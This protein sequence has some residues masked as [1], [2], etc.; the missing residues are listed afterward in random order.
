M[1]Y[2]AR[3]ADRH[4]QADGSS[5][6]KAMSVL[7]HLL[8]SSTAPMLLLDKWDQNLDEEYN[9]NI[10]AIFEKFANGNQHT[11]FLQLLYQVGE[12]LLLQTST[13]LLPF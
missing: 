2:Q 12:E 9:G 1:G 13:F 3:V 6:E 11:T 4:N 8:R 10:D 5:G 7:R